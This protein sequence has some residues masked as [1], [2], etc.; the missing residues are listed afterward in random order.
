MPLHTGT[1]LHAAWRKLAGLHPARLRLAL[2]VALASWVVTFA[3]V[4]PLCYIACRAVHQESGR[5]AA[6]RLQMARDAKRAEILAWYERQFVS[7]GQLAAGSDARTTFTEL[8]AWGKLQGVKPGD[9]FPVK[10]PGYQALWKHGAALRD[11][12][13]LG[14][15]LD[16]F[17]IDGQTGQ[18][19]FTTHNDIDNGVNLNTEPYSSS[20]LAKCWQHCREATGAQVVDQ[21][22]ASD[23]NL[24]PPGYSGQNLFI[25]LPLWPKRPPQA[26]IA[27][28]LSTAEIDYLLSN[29]RGYGASGEAYITGK[30]LRVRNK[31]RLQMLWWKKAGKPSL[32]APAQPATLALDYVWSYRG[33]SQ[34]RGIM[35]SISLYGKPALTAYTRLFPDYDMLSATTN[36]E[37]DSF[38]SRPDQIQL[39]RLVLVVEQPLSE[40]YAP[41][42]ALTALL[43]ALAVV[44]LALAWCIHWAIGKWVEHLPHL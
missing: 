22:Y 40:V 11:F 9:S 43:I 15:G 24:Y 38:W 37:Y 13:D 30:D 18:V 27:L 19:V 41:A 7:L 28:Q 31:P 1:A 29:G 3:A 25:A 42:R 21:A 6:A 34:A 8:Q 4:A 12:V 17:L 39:P 26:I 14:C 33:D 10:A 35:R 20:E 2:K 23:Y 44:L 5:A 36:Y 32:K 16:L